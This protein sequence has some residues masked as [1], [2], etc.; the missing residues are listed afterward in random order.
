[1]HLLVRVIR[2]RVAYDGNPVAELSSKANGPFEACMRDEPLDYELL[3]AVLLELQIQVR[4]PNI[5][6]KRRFPPTS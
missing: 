5:I 6:L 2:R 4:I 3:N 1:M